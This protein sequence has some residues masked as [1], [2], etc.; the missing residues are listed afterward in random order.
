MNKVV[1]FEIPCD[2][3]KRASEFYSKV[4]AWN[5]SEIPEMKYTMAVTG[6]TDEQNM[7]LEKG[8]ISGGLFNRADMDTPLPHPMVTMDV[9][10][11]EDSLKKVVEAG[12]EV[13]KE[14]TTVGDMGAVAYFKDTEGN[15]NGIWEDAKKG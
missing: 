10:N 9:D 7:P 13:V 4:F 8:F 3:A 14:R 2:D 5:M 6:P 15:I 12:G 1:H 11:I